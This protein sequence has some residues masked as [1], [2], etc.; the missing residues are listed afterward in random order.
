MAG[1][2]EYLDMLR[3]ADLPDAGEG[4]A[5]IFQNERFERVRIN[6]RPRRVRDV[7]SDSEYEEPIPEPVQVPEPGLRRVD[8][9]ETFFNRT[10][11]PRGR[12]LLPLPPGQ[13][14]S[15]RDLAPLRPVG[16]FPAR[17]VLGPAATASSSSTSRPEPAGV[18]ETIPLV[19]QETVE[20]YHDAHSDDSDQ[21]YMTYRGERRLVD[22]VVI[23]RLHE[24][25]LRES[26]PNYDLWMTEDDLIV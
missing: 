1:D 22:D 26:D 7:E 13:A 23:E 15:A 21:Y 5:W 2:N 11:L 9:D 6:A 20:D 8:S 3:A 14:G 16:G 25:E 10:A 17:P 18:Q 4:F 19:V 12:A 24:D